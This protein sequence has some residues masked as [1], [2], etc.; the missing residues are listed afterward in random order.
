MRPDHMREFTYRFRVNGR[1]AKAVFSRDTGQ[2]LK[3]VYERRP[4]E[5]IEPSS[6]GTL[7]VA[8]RNYHHKPHEADAAGKWGPGE[9]RRCE[10][11]ADDDIAAILEHF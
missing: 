4:I 9:K 10:K 7:W 6:L 2:L 5:L 3:A 11:F 8:R 1:D